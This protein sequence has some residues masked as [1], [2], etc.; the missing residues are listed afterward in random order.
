MVARVVPADGS[1]FGPDDRHDK[2][3]GCFDAVK[4]P[5]REHPDVP[6]LAVLAHDF[7]SEF[8]SGC[9]ESNDDAKDFERGSWSLL[10]RALLDPGVNLGERCYEL[11]W[12][13]RAESGR[14][15][16]RG[17]HPARR[18]YLDQMCRDQLREPAG[19]G[20]SSEKEAEVMCAGAD[21]SEAIDLRP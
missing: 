3:R 8:D 21:R 11:G 13:C 1:D 14:Q 20:K 18:R 6:I 17:P 7:V 2:W 10:G 19:V 15:C 16:C 12:M 5:G 9:I 4:K